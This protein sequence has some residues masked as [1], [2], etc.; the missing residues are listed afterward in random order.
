MEQAALRVVLP[1]A[2]PESQEDFLHRLL[3]LRAS[4]H[5]DGHAVNDPGVA[6]IQDI[7]GVDIPP[8]YQLDERLIINVAIDRTVL[9]HRAGNSSHSGC[10]I[11]GVISVYVPGAALGLT[12]RDRGRPG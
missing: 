11:G 1:G 5:D 4:E 7:E 12:D 3:R 6:P 8:G 2:R 9:L 10:V